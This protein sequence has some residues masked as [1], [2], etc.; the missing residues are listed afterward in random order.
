MNQGPKRP[1][2]FSNAI[3]WA[4]VV[5]LLGGAVWLALR[6]QLGREFVVTY[7]PDWGGVATVHA[8]RS[9]AEPTLHNLAVQRIQALGTRAVPP[10]MQTLIDPNPGERAESAQ[11][12][13]ILGT[14]AAPALPSLLP[15][16]DDPAPEV[17]AAALSALSSVGASQEELR[18]RM[19]KALVDEDARVRS[20]GMSVLTSLPFAGPSDAE[21]L[22]ELLSSPYADI[23]QQTCERL[24]ALG[25]DAKIAIVRLEQM[26]NDDPNENVR[27]EAE[28]AW[29]LISGV[30]P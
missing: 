18:S 21:L 4:V 7:L 22:L 29:E 28:E 14:V 12:L 11:A 8:R 25:P 19:R 9:L 26:M 17:R 15:L 5:G 3:K 10:L 6:S 23:R 13:A 30:E 2:T 1:L 27:H 24:P 20:S 16:T